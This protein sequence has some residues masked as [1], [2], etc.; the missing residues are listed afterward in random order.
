M[1]YLRNTVLVMG[2]D[3][4][5]C[6]HR[7]VLTVPPQRNKSC[8]VLTNRDLSFVR[9]FG[10]SRGF[11]WLKQP[12]TPS[13]RAAAKL[14]LLAGPRV[15]GL[16]VPGRGDAAVASLQL[17]QLCQKKSLK[18]RRPQNKSSLYTIREMQCQITDDESKLNLSQFKSVFHH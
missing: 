4:P 3:S 12:K 11:G 1:T 7:E 5:F 15:P 16:P 13:G 14:L 17:S 10:A 2:S 8:C 18:T 6:C 9:P